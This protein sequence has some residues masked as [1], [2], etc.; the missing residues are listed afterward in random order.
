MN[1]IMSIIRRMGHKLYLIRSLSMLGI[2][3]K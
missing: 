3:N 2:M 1:I